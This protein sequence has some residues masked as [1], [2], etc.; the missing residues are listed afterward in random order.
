MNEVFV[1]EAVR[2]PIAAVKIARV[3]GEKNISRIDVLSPEELMSQVRDEL[4]RRIGIDP[5]AVEI[6]R[7]GS[8]VAQKAESTMFHAPAKRLM[9]KEGSGRALALSAST[10]EAACATGLVA[11]EEAV[12]E[13]QLGRV[14]LALA[15]GVEMMSRHP[16]DVIESVRRSPETGE[17]IE[18]LADRKT[19]ALG[20]TR[21]ELDLYSF[22]SY[23][24]AHIHLYDYEPRIV[25]IFLPGETNPVL[26][27]DEGAM[28]EP[29]PLEVVKRS[30]L[31]Y[32]EKR[33]VRCEMITA[34]HSSKYG[35]AAALV[36]LASKQALENY[37]LKPLAKILAVESWSEDDPK[38]FIVAPNTAIPKA[39][40]SARVPFIEVGTFIVNEAFAPSPVSF[41]KQF[42]I[43]R[44]MVNP[45]GGAIAF[46]HPFGA[47][48]AILL[49]MLLTI[50]EKEAKR[51]GVLG[52]CA[53][54]GEASACVI[55][56]VG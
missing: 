38:D 30:K 48:G 6:F 15:G 54:G 14:H 26:T 41:M 10:V 12:E 39:L 50:L 2:S 40:N 45:W 25:P 56:R 51:Y 31:L 1:V 27:L 53:A 17:L 24:L 20:L 46:G 52:I 22:Q 7:V 11:I 21:D 23:G 29:S 18:F 35:D 55:E 42:G 9:R 37:N 4:F 36:L 28:R 43:P 16:D 5:R 34:A 32:D 33:G 3:G 44:E 49:V 47:T 13:I 19:K 8:L